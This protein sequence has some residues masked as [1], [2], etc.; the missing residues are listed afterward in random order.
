MKFSSRI[1]NFW[2]YHKWKVIFSLFL[3]TSF[4]YLSIASV[5]EHKAD[6]Y[7][8]VVTT[9]SFA[10]EDKEL[11]CKKLGEAAGDLNGDGEL[12]ATCQFIILPDLAGGNVDQ[13]AYQVLQAALLSRR[14][15]LFLFSD[16]I[17]ATGNFDEFLTDHINK[18][19][20]KEGKFLPL[21][22]DA[23]SAPAT[24]AGL[25]IAMRLD[26]NASKDPDSFY[27]VAI[28]VAEYFGLKEA[29]N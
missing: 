21:P 15:E 17:V 18:S 28:K 4:V 3:I 2:Y 5:S 14:Y 1:A 8:V 11:I 22:Q 12:W 26:A 6:F 27:S 16:D 29:S 19:A 10:E 23:I 20:G 7:G 24:E 9:K 13:Q 25:H